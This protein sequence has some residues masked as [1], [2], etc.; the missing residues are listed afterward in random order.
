MCEGS[1][2][3]HSGLKTMEA[4]ERHVFLPLSFPFSVSQAV[5][6]SARGKRVWEGGARAVKCR[7]GGVEGALVST[8]GYFPKD[9]YRLYTNRRC[10][11]G[12]A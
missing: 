10:I 7:G 5:K 4:S 9:A 11:Y 3:Y 1:G 8:L 12:S 2:G 6:G